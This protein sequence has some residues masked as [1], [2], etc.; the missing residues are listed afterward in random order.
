MGYENI[1]FPPDSMFL[2]TGA[3]GFIGSNLVEALLKLGYK[4]RGL[5]NFSTGKIDNI[6]SFMDN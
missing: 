5:D 6:K 2:V 4:V 1:K 3:A